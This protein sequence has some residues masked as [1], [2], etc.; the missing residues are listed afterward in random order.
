MK[1]KRGSITLFVLFSGLFFIMFLSTVL[2]YS[3]IKRQTE[4]ELTKSTE[5]IYGDKDAE[6]IYQN[7][8]GVGA[9]PIYTKEQL[10]KIASGEN[11]QIKEEGGKI[12]NFSPSS[13]YILKNDIEFEYNGVWKMPTLTD[14]GKIESSNKQIKIKDTSKTNTT[15]NIYYYYISDNGYAFAVT[16]LKHKYENLQLSFDSIKN[17]FSGR[18][19]SVT[20]W[21]DLTGNENNGTVRGATWVENGLKFDGT[22]DDVIINSQDFNEVTLEVTITTSEVDKEYN[23]ISNLQYGGYGIIIYNNT[24][25]MQVYVDGEYKYAQSEV[26]AN[27]I[28]HVIG[29]FDGKIIKLYINGVLQQPTTTVTGTFTQTTL[30]TILALGANPKEGTT[31]ANYFKRNNTFS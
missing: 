15:E 19:V 13:T 5:K 12:Y 26:T 22:D 23:L 10:F 28:Y 31:N 9:V 14:G 8:F 16:E 18:D 25:R 4:A 29:T 7:Y 1:N 11:V 3:S 24:L 6:E 30:N 17:T 21:Q 2:M 27:K 20:K